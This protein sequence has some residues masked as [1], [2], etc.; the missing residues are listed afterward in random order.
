MSDKERNQDTTATPFPTRLVGELTIHAS[1]SAENQ[2][3]FDGKD[4]PIN[5][6]IEGME[7]SLS[8]KAPTNDKIA[9]VKKQNLF[10]FE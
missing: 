1:V 3:T 6:V 10:V 5:S 9:R 8:S 7:V 4:V 2:V